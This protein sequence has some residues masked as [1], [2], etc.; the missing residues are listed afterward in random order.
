MRRRRD[1]IVTNVLALAIL[2]VVALA[3]WWDA[4][5]FGLGVLVFMDLLVLFRSRFGRSRGDSEEE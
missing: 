5:L 4:A 2:I 1:L 3:G